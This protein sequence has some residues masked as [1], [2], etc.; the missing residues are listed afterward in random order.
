MNPTSL[1]K[2]SG[3]ADDEP[4]V[5]IVRL[6][7]QMDNVTEA[8]LSLQRTQAAQHQA[9]MQE[10]AALRERIDTIQREEREA[11]ERFEQRMAERQERFEQHITERLDRSDH[12]ITDRL[13]RFEQHFTT[14]LDRLTLWVAGLLMANVLAVAS[15][16]ARIAIT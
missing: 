5:R 6:E 8:I 4:I 12:H 15:L 16:F 13:D 3:A 1:D 9:M 2:Q 11:R 10:F 7:T 14:R